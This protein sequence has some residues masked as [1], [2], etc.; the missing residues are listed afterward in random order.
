MTTAISIR[1]LTKKYIDVWQRQ[2][3]VAVNNLDL[4]VEEG[5]IFGFLG[6]NGAGK[7]TTIKMLL[8]L[9]FPTAG[10]A[11]ILGKPMGDN[12]VKHLISYLPEETYFYESM[13]GWDLM[14][15]YGRL[16]RI[17]QPERKRRIQICLE[18][19]RLQ[20]DAWHRA[21]RGYSKGMRQRIGIAQAL[22]NDPQL[23]FLDEPT[24]GLDPIAHAELRDIVASLKDEGKTVFLSSHQLADVEMICTRVAIIHR[25]KLLKTGTIKELVEGEHTEITVRGKELANGLIDRLR[26]IATSVEPI[27]NDTL[28]L[29]SNDPERVSAL[30]DLVRGAKGQVISVMP[31]RRTLEEVFVE[32]VRKEELASIGAASEEGV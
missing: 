5:E 31:H 18:K 2:E 15:F 16:F 10:D 28:K 11:T 12:S 3:V 26:P 1:G 13:T 23:L 14:D 17:P 20:P 6:R 27:G 22:I 25:G 24:S 7:T 4:E 19:V 32:T 30:I 21:I 29:S 8:G 9:I